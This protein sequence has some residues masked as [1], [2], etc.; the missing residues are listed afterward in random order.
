MSLI[1][2][3]QSL[4]QFNDS[5]C[6]WPQLIVLVLC[7]GRCKQKMT[8]VLYVILSLGPETSGIGSMVT[9]QNRLGQVR[10]EPY[11]KTLQTKTFYLYLHMFVF[12]SDFLFRVITSVNFYETSGL[13]NVIIL[14]NLLVFTQSLAF[15]FH[16]TSYHRAYIFPL[17]FRT[18]Q[19]KKKCK[20][21][22]NIRHRI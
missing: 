11:V 2:S 14:S 17:I 13:C 10:Q 8:L 15:Y 9:L 16:R 19:N 5:D 1:P 3:G 7:N 12:S 6:S 21:T 18:S 20:Y 22:N 4:V